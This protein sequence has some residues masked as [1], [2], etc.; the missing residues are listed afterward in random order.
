[1]AFVFL[2]TPTNRRVPL[3][4]SLPLSIV[5]ALFE[6]VLAEKRIC[7]TSEHLPKLV[8]VCEAF[9]SFL[10]PLHWKN[11]YIP[12]GYCGHRRFISAR[13]SCSSL[14]TETGAMDL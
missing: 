8:F 4:E 3:F 13:S 7:F 10:F 14:P 2:V 11:V 12:V 6:F 9:L 1:M 5:V